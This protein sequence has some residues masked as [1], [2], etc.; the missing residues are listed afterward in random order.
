MS[1][2]WLPYADRAEAERRIGALPEGVEIDFFTDEPR[3][4]ELPASVADVEFFVIPYM[5]GDEQLARAEEMT[6]LKVIQTLTAGVENFIPRVP[7]GVTLC[8]AAG[9]HDAST[10]EL[11]IA[12][13]LASGRRLDGF[14]RNMPDGRWDSVFGRALADQRV[15]IVGYGNIGEAIE[16]RLSGFEVASVTRVARRRRTG[17][18]AVWAIDDLDLL[19]PEADVVFVIAPHTPQTEGLF[20]ARRLALLPDDALLVNVARGPLVVTDAL[21]AETSSGR[22]RAAL[23]VV[24]PEPLP[25]DHPLWHSPG[26]F[27]SPHVGGASTAFFPRADRLIAA[28]LRRFA[29]GEEL[30]NVIDTGRDSG[31]GI[32]G[33]AGMSPKRDKS[34]QPEE[35]DCVFCMIIAGRLPSRVIYEDENAIAFLDIAAWHRG[36]TLVVTREHVP[37]LVVRPAVV[38]QDRARRGRGGPDA[39][40]PVGRRRHQR[41]VLGQG[42]AGQTVFHMHMHVV[43]RYAD[44]PG[45]DRLVNHGR[46]PRGRT[47]VGLP[48]DPGERVSLGKS[49][50][51]S[52]RRSGG[53]RSELLPPFVM[54]LLIL[55]YVIQYGK[56]SPWE[57]STIDLQVYVAAV[58][59]MLAGKDIFATTTPFW[60]LYFIYPPIAAILMTPL[61]FGPYA[62]WQVIWTAGLVLAQQSVL[63]RCGVPRGWM[64]GLVGV[65]VVLAV[66]PIRTTLGYGQVNTML[67]ALV[68][69]DLLPD[70]PGEKRRIPRGTLIGLAAA[71]KLTPMLFVIFA[72]LINASGWR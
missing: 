22:L 37:D 50:S 3:G 63:K 41:V 56:V 47:Q 14:A 62:F 48:A 1:L 2:A 42:D 66:E 38:A 13:A 15:L 23:D 61:A 26:V 17:E 29:A 67:M 71:I 60:N 51:V 39:A 24:D 34:G 72:F 69:A 65:A 6:N 16:R 18:V 59:D 25:A 7:D 36:H 31:P 52:L 19:L 68:V 43:P 46:G 57:P 45:L 28:Q 4:S 12:L 5:R 70:R 21:L 54:A 27:I 20:D 64:L 11:A 30:A 40:A 49:A 9:V 10:A 33:S 44:E 8:N 53:W 58:K 55:P 35:P 32:R